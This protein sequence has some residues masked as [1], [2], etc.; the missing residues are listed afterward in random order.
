MHH[1]RRNRSDRFLHK[2]GKWSNVSNGR[3]RRQRG[4]LRS[5][6]GLAGVV[7]GSGEGGGKVS[8]GKKYRRH[9]TQTDLGNPRREE[10][11]DE[12]DT[13]REK[14]VTFKCTGCEGSIIRSLLAILWRASNLKCA[15]CTGRHESRTLETLACRLGK[16]VQG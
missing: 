14:R 10:W 5:G 2:F 12:S 15:K 3:S 11:P 6:S 7:Q 8:S 9:H 4:G 13:G 16:C 1:R